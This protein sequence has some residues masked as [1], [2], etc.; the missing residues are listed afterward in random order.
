MEAMKKVRFSTYD[1]MCGEK[2]EFDQLLECDPPSC[3][4]SMCPV[5]QLIAIIQSSEVTQT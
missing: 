3:E 2:D 1:C 5:K 4:L